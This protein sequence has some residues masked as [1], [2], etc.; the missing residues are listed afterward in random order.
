VIVVITSV[1][2]TLFRSFRP[3]NPVAAEIAKRAF[4]LSS[5]GLLS[6][7][8]ATTFFVGYISSI[9]QRFPVDLTA[10][11]LGLVAPSVLLIALV[12]SVAPHSYSA[13][14]KSEQQ[15]PANQA[16]RPNDPPDAVNA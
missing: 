15:H 11:F 5:Y 10:V 16:V 9:S 6:Y 3:D 2:L 12:Q 1:A 14:E 8:V 4:L 13:K 7:A